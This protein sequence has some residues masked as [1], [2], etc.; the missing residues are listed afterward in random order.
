MIVNNY[1]SIM[2]IHHLFIYSGISESNSRLSLLALFK[3]KNALI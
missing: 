3:D 1:V 2:V